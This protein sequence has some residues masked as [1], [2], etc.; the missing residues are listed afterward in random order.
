[1]FI[2]QENAPES[3]NGSDVSNESTF[4]SIEGRE[5][6][7]GRLSGP[8]LGDGNDKVSVGSRSRFS[9]E[10]RATDELFKGKITE[11]TGKIQNSNNSRGKLLK[12]Q[13]GTSEKSQTSSWVSS[14]EEFSSPLATQGKRVPVTHSKRRGEETRENYRSIVLSYNK[15][16]QKVASKYQVC[17]TLLCIIYIHFMYV[18]YYILCM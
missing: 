10:S 7:L 9:E 12:S 5:S 14:E 16:K 18:I 4:K 11:S 2:D 3:N 6:P 15:H 13:S 8:S 17:M 1:M